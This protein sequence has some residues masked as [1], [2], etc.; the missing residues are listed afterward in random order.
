V[1]RSLI[2]TG[3]SLAALRLAPAAASAESLTLQAPTSAVEDTAVKIVAS[4]EAGIDRRLWI[5]IEPGEG[6]CAPTAAAQH[7]RPAAS[8]STLPRE[9][10]PAR[11][12]RSSRPP[13]A[14]SAS[15]WNAA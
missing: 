11:P 2:A 14:V 12:P 5:Y 15:C 9:A 3:V 13:V 6:G 7:Y 8:S 10:A 4:G 1:L